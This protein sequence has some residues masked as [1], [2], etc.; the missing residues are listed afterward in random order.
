MTAIK[1]V[2]VLIV[3]SYDTYVR[4]GVRSDFH[5]AEGEDAAQVIMAAINALGPQGGTVFLAPGTYNC[6]TAI[7]VYHGAASRWRVVS[8][9]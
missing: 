5:V 3:T 2:P 1:E 6:Q 4:F 8:Y 9:V 7:L